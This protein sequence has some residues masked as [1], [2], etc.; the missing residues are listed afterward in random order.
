MDEEYKTK[1]KEYRMLGKTHE[2]SIKA[3]HEDWLI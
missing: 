3:I 2:E 1:Y